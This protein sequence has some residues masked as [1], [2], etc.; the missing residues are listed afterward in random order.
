MICL[1]FNEFCYKSCTYKHTGG[2]CGLGGKKMQ[3]HIHTKQTVE[4][5]ETPC[6]KNPT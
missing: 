5:F 1:M 3:E 4:S 6:K 2:L